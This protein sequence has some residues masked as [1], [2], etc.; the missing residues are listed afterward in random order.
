MISTDSPLTLKQVEQEEKEFHEKRLEVAAQDGLLFVPEGTGKKHYAVASN[1]GD[2]W[3]HIHDCLCQENST[4]SHV[5]THHVDCCDES[6]STPTVG[7]FELTDTEAEE[8]KKH[9]KVVDVSIDESY[10]AGTYNGLYE[11]QHVLTPTPRYGKNVINGR[12][13]CI[14]N[15]SGR[16]FIPS[17]TSNPDVSSAYEGRTG[18]QVTRH[19]KFLDLFSTRDSSCRTLNIDPEQ[20]GDGTDVDVIVG[21]TSAWYGH[22]EF[23]KTGRSEPQNYIQ[24]SVLR[25]GFSTSATTGI[26]GVLDLVLDSP[27]YLDP[28][29]F[30][31]NPGARL[32]TRWDGTKVPN[33]QVAKDWWRNEST[34]YRSAKYVSTDR[35]GTATVGSDQDFGTISINTAHTRA[36][37]NGS[38]TA[39]HTSGGTHAT[40]CMSQAY[41]KTCGWAYNANKWHLNIIWDSGNQTSSNYFRIMKVFH[42]NKPN[43]TSD[44]TKNPTISSNSWGSMW[45]I[46][47]S[48]YFHRKSGNGN[49]GVD[50]SSA[51]PEFLKYHYYYGRT[52]LYGQ[53]GGI[54]STFHSIGKELIDAGVFFVNSSGNNNQKLVLDGHPDYNNYYGYS[55]TTLA[56]AEANGYMLH[57]PGS[58]TSIGRV[59]VGGKDVYRAFSIGALDAGTT[60][61]SNG[62]S[63]G[64]EHKAVYSNCGEGIDLYTIGNLGWAAGHNYFAHSYDRNYIYNGQTSIDS[65]FGFFAGTSSA[66]PVA[67]GLM[68]TKLQ[69]NRD[70]I[71]S[72]MKN[73]LKNSV[74]NQSADNFEQGL[75]PTDPES[76]DWNTQR[77]LHGGDR[78]ILWDA[79]T[80]LDQ[81]TT[82]GPLTIKGP[83]N[84]ST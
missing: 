45:S 2:D 21:D 79:P 25:A 6:K 28:D 64:R 30:E 83:L 55:Y 58:P 50:M 73:W 7:S 35:G 42:Q 27:Y 49:D 39:F 51:F 19:T 59:E 40:P 82:V 1:N 24:G 46:I 26:C 3:N 66:C 14:S 80:E 34:T 9:P 4:E 33:E 81:Q 56:Q 38:N 23:V 32:V 75:E 44:N 61:D 78:K 74:T 20:L 36:K 63:F 77:S 17:P 16:S 41:G 72:D 22:V 11:R 8:L 52:E 60:T 15:E 71:W 76:T 65:K 54:G 70:W 62:N 37:S 13:L 84:I 48:H 10:Y 57:R 5:P 29:F 12:T 53:I 67:T 69:Y 18:P 31:A 47:Q 43:R 68:A